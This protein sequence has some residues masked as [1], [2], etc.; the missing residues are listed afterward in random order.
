MSTEVTQAPEAS[1]KRRESPPGATEG[2][3]AS[4]SA[5]PFEIGGTLTIIFNSFKAAEDFV[6]RGVAH[7]LLV[8]GVVLI[9]LPALG[10]IASIP[11]LNGLDTREYPATIIV[12]AALMVAGAVIRVI[13][14]FSMRRAAAEQM[15]HYFAAR[16]EAYVDHVTSLD[17]LQQESPNPIHDRI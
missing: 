3:T 2:S 16:T 12:G 17:K 14:S 6:E 10:K 13:D 5:D 11:W 7:A 4:A 1:T 8:I 15:S 9:V